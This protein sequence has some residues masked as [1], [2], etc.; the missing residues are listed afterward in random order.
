MKRGGVVERLPR[1]LAQ[2]RILLDHS[3]AVERGLHVE[4][5]LLAALQDRVEAAQH[6]HRQDH[7]PVLAAHV[8]IAQ[9][10]VGDAPDVIRDPVQVAVA[11]CHFG[12]CG[13]LLLALSALG[14]R[15][16]GERCIKLIQDTE[17]PL[18][19]TP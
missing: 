2:G 15:G 19:P 13:G 4:D 12:E 17:A 11:R 1:R 8:K 3:G 14:V 5:R 16:A 9:N 6:G 18:L 7:V 10:I